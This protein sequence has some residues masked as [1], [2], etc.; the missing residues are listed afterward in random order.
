MKN[1]SSKQ[2]TKLKFDFYFE[3]N[4]SINCLSHEF[5]SFST[6]SDEIMEEINSFYQKFE[7]FVEKT[8][9]STIVT[10]EVFLESI[11]DYK[12]LEDFYD[13]IYEFIHSNCDGLVNIDCTEL[14]FIHLSRSQREQLE[15]EQ[16]ANDRF[17]K[18]MTEAGIC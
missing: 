4:N 5:S 7:K 1:T 11:S 9:C 8:I 13:K 10:K 2:A 3:D 17:S 6:N 14:I 16:D 18:K 15:F 12:I